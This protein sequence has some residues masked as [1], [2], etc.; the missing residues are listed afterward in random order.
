MQ[1]HEISL[2]EQFVE[3][4][5]LVAEFGSAIVNVDY[6]INED[7]HTHCSTILASAAT[8]IAEAQNAEGFAV[9]LNAHQVFLCPI[10]CFHRGIC[11]GQFA[12]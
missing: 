6:V 10:I 3:A 4:N 5:L 9:E 12:S 11:T 2:S 1:T 8:D 7:F